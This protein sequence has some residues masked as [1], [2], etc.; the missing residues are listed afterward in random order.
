MAC[1]GCGYQRVNQIAPA[2]ATIVT[3][4]P[5]QSGMVRKNAMTTWATTRI[6]KAAAHTPLIMVCRNELRICPIFLRHLLASELQRERPPRDQRA[7][8][9][10]EQ[11]GIEREPRFEDRPII[12]G[13]RGEDRQ[14]A[15]QPHGAGFKNFDRF[16][17][18]A[19]AHDQQRGQRRR[20]DQRKKTSP[21]RIS[22]ANRTN[23]PKLRRMFMGLPEPRASPP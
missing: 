2:S 9:D 7:E 12:A 13:D 6:T 15:E 14:S 11:S 1:V 18:A 20:R 21:N 17:A 16:A 8:H 23:G 5:T 4:M 10:R 3:T 19:L 22:T